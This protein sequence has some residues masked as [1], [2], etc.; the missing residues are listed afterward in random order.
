MKIN[1][2]H[3]VV[4]WARVQD[5]EIGEWIHRCLCDVGTDSADAESAF[6]VAIS[7]AE[8]MGRLVAILAEKQMVTAPEVYHIGRGYNNDA[9]TF[10]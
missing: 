9:A 10:D 7:C 6:A 2:G 4:G 5:G 8:A 1:S 3:K